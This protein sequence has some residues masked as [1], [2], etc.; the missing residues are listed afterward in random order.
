MRE[1]IFSDETEGA[2]ERG[3]TLEE[4][5][6]L[7]T[8]RRRKFSVDLSPKTRSTAIKGSLHRLRTGSMY[9]QESKTKT[10]NLSLKLFRYNL[11]MHPNRQ[12]GTIATSIA[13]AARAAA[14]AA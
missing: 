4:V 7:E 10:Q 6:S 14:P 11:S 13:I 8:L 5:P 3:F 12:I 9:V 2:A 1:T